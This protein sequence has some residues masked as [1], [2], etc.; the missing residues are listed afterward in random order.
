MSERN[1]P[2][3]GIILIINVIL[4]YVQFTIFTN[5]G[6]AASSSDEPIFAI[7]AFFGLCIMFLIS[8]NFIIILIKSM[9]SKGFESINKAVAIITLISVLATMFQLFLLFLMYIGAFE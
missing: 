2:N 4:M 1:F 8:V 9:G 5:I 6:P 7:M 3:I